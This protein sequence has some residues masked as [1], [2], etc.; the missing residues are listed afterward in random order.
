MTGLWEKGAEGATTL[1]IV[2]RD[3]D[4]THGFDCYLVGPESVAKLTSGC[5]VPELEINTWSNVFCA[6]RVLA[7]AV[8]EAFDS[9]AALA[10][11]DDDTPHRRQ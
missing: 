7:P 4:T 11:D 9:G 3:L 2:T 5:F 10:F 1:E 8:V 6:H